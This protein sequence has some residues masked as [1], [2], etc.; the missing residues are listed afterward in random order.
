MGRRFDELCEILDLEEI[1]LN[2]FRGQNERGQVHRLFGGQVLSQALM[3]AGRTVDELVPHSLHGYFLRPGDP[4]IP[5]LYTVDRIRDGR[6]FVTRRVVAIQHGRAIFNLAAS[7]HAPEAGYDHQSEMPDAPEPESLP[8]WL[9]QLREHSDRVPDFKGREARGE[10]PFDFRFVNLPT[11]LGGKGGNDPN[12]I[13]LRAGGHVAADDALLHQ[14]LLTY[15]TDMSLIDTIARH[16]AQRTRA[17]TI[18]MAASLDHAVWFHRPIRA[19]E[20]VLYAQ[21]S[22]SAASGRGFA[23]G[24]LYSRDGVLLASVAQEGLIRPPRNT[25][26]VPA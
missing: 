19:D 1:D 25:P 26:D 24:S 21:D 5:V 18:S 13:W 15:A 7:F 4:K 23:R 2:I 16:H 14:C 17:G 11:Y 12:L 22:P 6:S 20:W 8:T 3:A 10:P 9:E